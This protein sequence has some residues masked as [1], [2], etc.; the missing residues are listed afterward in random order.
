MEEESLRLQDQY[1]DP[2]VVILDYIEEVCPPKYNPCFI[3]T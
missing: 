2:L 1:R 3:F